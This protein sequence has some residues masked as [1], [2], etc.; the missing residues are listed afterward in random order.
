MTP[1]GRIA[2]CGLLAASAG[3]SGCLGVEST[4][5]K[6]ARLAKQAAAEIRQAEKGLEIRRASRTITVV[7]KQVVQDPTGVAAVVQLRN[8]G[9]TQVNVP[10]AV[11][12]LGAGGRKLYANTIPGLDR[13]LVS[14]PLVPRG[15]TTLWINNQITVAGRSRSLKVRVGDGTPAPARTAPRIT[16]SKLRQGRDEDGAYVEGV[17]TNRSAVLQKRLTIS[18]VSVAGGRVRAAG[19]SVIEKLPPAAQARKPTRF[20]AFFIGKPAGGAITCTAPAV[21]WKG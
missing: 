18:C 14:A 7:S 3:L 16:L 15:R 8:R 21:A 10:I 12:V 19:R 13:S 20:T 6:S 4:Q 17:V 9:R 5:D 1:G 11:T 2:A